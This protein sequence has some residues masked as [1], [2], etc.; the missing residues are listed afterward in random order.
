MYEIILLNMIKTALK[1]YNKQSY[2][3]NGCNLMNKTM[4]ANISRTNTGRISRIT[5]WSTRVDHIHRYTLCTHFE[6]WERME[7]RK[8]KIYL[9]VLT[10]SI[11]HFF[12]RP[13]ELPLRSPLETHLRVLPTFGCEICLN[14]ILKAKSKQ[15]VLADLP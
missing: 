12:R 9:F 7:Y 5:N 1:S 15:I 8:R 4:S 3:A 6:K 13:A 11:R 10:Y 2:L 14:A